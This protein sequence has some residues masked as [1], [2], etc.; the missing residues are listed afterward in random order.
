MVGVSL[1]FDEDNGTANQ[2][3]LHETQQEIYYLFLHFLPF[4]FII[5]PL[6]RERLKVA[7]NHPL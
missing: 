2:D 4:N 7:T 5:A 6:V 1:I 3:E